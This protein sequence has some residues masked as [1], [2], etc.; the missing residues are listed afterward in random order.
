MTRSFTYGFLVVAAI[1]AA[2]TPAQAVSYS[3]SLSVGDTGLSADGVWDEAVTTLRWVVDD[4]TTAGKWHYSYTLTAAQGQGAGISHV[5]FEA[6]DSFGF[7]NLFSPTTDPEGWIS[8]EENG[9][10]IT[11]HEPGGGN[12]DMPSAVYGIKFNAAADADTTTLTL[13][14]DSDRVPVWGD[15]YAKGGQG[16]VWN[17]GFLTD[18]EDPADDPSNGSVAYHVLVPDTTTVAIP[19]PGSLV[20]GSLGMV[21]VGWGRGYR[22][23]I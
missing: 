7:S 10:E 14:F 15:F 8:Q 5:I 21:L 4:T 18:D 12:P 23:L 13:S 2:V 11:T 6:S 17:A 3:G 1:V 16:S 19:A 9:T 22:R 20:L